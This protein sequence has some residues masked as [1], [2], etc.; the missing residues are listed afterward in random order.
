MTDVLK[1]VYERMEISV[2]H[3]P[4]MILDLPVMCEL[5]KKL[6]QMTAKLKIIYSRYEKFCFIQYAKAKFL[7]SQ[8]YKLANMLVRKII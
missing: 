7:I 6:K 3:S 4:T 2:A 5:I 1:L 8:D